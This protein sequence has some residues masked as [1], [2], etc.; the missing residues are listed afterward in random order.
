M[1]LFATLRGKLAKAMVPFEPFRLYWG[2]YGGWKELL[3]SP[4]LWLSAILTW[5]CF[6][7]WI[8]R[9][10]AGDA[11]PVNEALLTVVPALMAFTLAGMA[12]LLALSGDKFVNAIRENGKENSLFMRVVAL[13]FHFILVQTLALIG[14][15]LSASY[16]SQD[17]LA[18]FAFLLT[19]YGIA[20]ALAIAAMLL[21]VSRIYNE[22]GGND[23][24]A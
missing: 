10:N 9:G 19:A 22:S 24:D 8:D 2:I 4:Y 21:N 15:F 23:D 12:I 6:P 16:P 11:R 1:R 7:L 18:G 3:K 13:F 14:A 17:W 5:A 20:S